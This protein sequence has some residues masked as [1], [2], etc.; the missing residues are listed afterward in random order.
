MFPTHRQPSPRAHP[1]TKAVTARSGQHTTK[2]T[3]TK[4]Y[5]QT[6]TRRSSGH[7]HDRR[8]LIMCSCSADATIAA[9]HHILPPPVGLAGK[10]AIQVNKCKI[11]KY[12]PTHRPTNHLGR[13]TVETHEEQDHGAH[14]TMQGTSGRLYTN[15]RRACQHAQYCM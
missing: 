7:P 6:A 9:A 12:P 11:S 14:I 1:H 15:G 8:V 2:P 5:P 13:R 10:E 3:Q 4:G